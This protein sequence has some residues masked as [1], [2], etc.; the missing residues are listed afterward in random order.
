M[1]SCPAKSCDALS[2]RGKY[3]RNLAFAG[4]DEN[5]SADEK[6]DVLRLAE[7]SSSVITMVAG[8]CHFDF[9]SFRL[10]WRYGAAKRLKKGAT[11]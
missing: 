2:L 9:S 4:E 5:M 10:V 8:L 3:Q 7:C 11:L 1:S 6:A